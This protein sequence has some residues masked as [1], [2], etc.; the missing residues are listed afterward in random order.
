MLTGRLNFKDR[1]TAVLGQETSFEKVAPFYFITVQDGFGTNALILN[2]QDFN[3]K[4]LY[5]I[6]HCNPKEM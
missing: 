1:N 2:L 6:N 5:N 4:S 3:L